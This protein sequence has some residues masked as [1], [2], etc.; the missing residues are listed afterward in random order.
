MRPDQG[1]S[2]FSSIIELPQYTAGRAVATRGAAEG[3]RG[4][5]DPI[6][7]LSRST[8]LTVSLIPSNISNIFYSP[9]LFFSW[10]VP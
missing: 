9:C 10:E 4:R 3:L 8:R 1:R 7:S 2:K 5:H 6:A